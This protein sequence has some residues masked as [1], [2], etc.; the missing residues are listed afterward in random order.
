MWAKVN[1]FRDT[2]GKKKRKKQMG[3]SYLMGKRK[4][5]SEWMQSAKGVQMEEGKKKSGVLLLVTTTLLIKGERKVYAGE[6]LF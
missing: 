5:V 6:Q 3:Q 2:I 4:H 1:T